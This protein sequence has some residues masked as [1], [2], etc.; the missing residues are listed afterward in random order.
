MRR[1][2]DMRIFG[3]AEMDARIINTMWSM[4][5]LL[6]GIATM[7]LAIAHAAA[8]ELPDLLERALGVIDLLSLPVLVLSTVKKAKC[9]E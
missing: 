7:I 9:K 8:A 2:K 1:A 4:S 6:I 5:L 3:D